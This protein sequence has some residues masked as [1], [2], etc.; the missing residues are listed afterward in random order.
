[1]SGDKRK[2]DVIGW[3]RLLATLVIAATVLWFSTQGD[4][5]AWLLR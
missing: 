2:N 3:V 5:H 4:I 1:M